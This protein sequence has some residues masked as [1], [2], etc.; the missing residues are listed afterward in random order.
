MNYQQKSI[1]PARPHRPLTPMRRR[2]TSDELLAMEE[3][4]I[5]H[6]DERV[7]LIDGDIITMATQLTACRSTGW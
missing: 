5:L 3:A 6:P 1:R 7:E 4:G 2:F